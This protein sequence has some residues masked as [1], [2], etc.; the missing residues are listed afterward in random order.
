MTATAGN[1]QVELS[2][3]HPGPDIDGYHIYRSTEPF[4]TKGQSQR[5]T[6]S[7]PVT[8]TSYTDTEVANETTYYYRMASLRAPNIGGL[9][10]QVSAMPTASSLIF[11]EDFSDGLDGKWVPFGS[12]QGR[13]VS[14]V[15]N[16]AP[17]FDNNGDANWDSGAYTSQTFDYSNGLEIAAD[18]YVPS[19]P[20]GCWVSGSFGVAQQSSVTGQSYDLAVEFRYNYNGSLCN[21]NTDATLW[22][23][24]RTADGDVESIRDDFLSDYLDAWHRYRIVIRPDQRV[25]FYVDDSLIYRTERQIDPAYTNR[26]LVLGRRS[27]SYGKVYHDN[28]VVRQSG[29]SDLTPP[30]GLVAS[31][32]DGQVELSWEHP[33][34]DIDGYHIYRSTE[35]FETKGQSQRITG[36]DPVTETSYTDTEVAN[37]TTYYYRMA[38]LRAPNIG[39]L[40][41]QVNA[42]PGSADLND[43]LVAYYPFDGNA[44]DASGNGNDGTVSGARLTSDRNG[45]SESAYEFDGSNF[46]ELPAWESGRY[47][48]RS[49]VGWI[50]AKDGG[51]H[52][53]RSNYDASRGGEWQLLWNDSTDKIRARTVIQPGNHEPVLY[54]SR[55]YE[56]DRWHF[57]AAVWDLES[58]QVKLFINGAPDGT[59]DV[60]DGYIGLG[61][62]GLSTDWKIGGTWNGGSFNGKIDDVRIYNRALSESEI[63]Q[64]HGNE[65]AP[66]PPI[67]GFTGIGTLG[68][69]NYYFSDNNE[70]TWNEASTAAREVGGH[71]AVITSQGEGDLISS[72][73]GGGI[74]TAWIGLTDQEKEGEFRWVTG[75]EVTYSNWGF[76]QPDDDKD[77]EDGVAI[78]AGNIPSR[79]PGSWND[80]DI[81][82]NDQRRFAFVLEISSRGISAPSNL[83]ASPG[84]GQVELSWEHPG[85]DIDGY[86]IYRSTEPFETKGQSQRIT[87]SDP[88]TE[89]SYTDTEVANET[90]YY[91]RMASLRAP[92]I[93]GLS[94]QVSATPGSADLNDGLVAYY[95]FDG[96]AND[97]SGNGNDGAVVGAVLGQDRFGSADS[98]YKLDGDGDYIQI[99]QFNFESEGL[100]IATWIFPEDLANGGT[101]FSNGEGS[102]SCDNGIRRFAVTGSGFPRVH[103]E[104][105]LDEQGGVQVKEQEWHFLSLT[106][107]HKKGEGKIYLDGGVHSTF[108]SSSIAKNINT[109]ATHALGGFLAGDTFRKRDWFDG[110]MDDVRIYN[111]A[112]SESEITSLY[113]SDPEEGI[114]PPSGLTASAGDSQVELSWELEGIVEVAH[115]AENAEDPIEVALDGKGGSEDPPT[116][117]VTELIVGGLTITAPEIVP[118][119]GDE[120]EISGTAIVNELLQFDG[121]LTVDTE[122]LT[123]EGEGLIYME[124]MG[125]FDEIGL[126]DGSFYF[127]RG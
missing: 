16:P 115:N 7:D 28:I 111:R 109:N 59:A 63:K 118:V 27:S 51:G 82:G 119:S 56:K 50:L 19:A 54:T 47:S 72:F 35:P 17:A 107:N 37:E 121:T 22:A 52:F 57:V 60:P 80:F 113:N 10:E 67:E 124:D 126:Y 43:G 55:S 32:G 2:W 11:S 9:S 83:V 103:I 114:L 112:L 94:E 95:P 105:L 101:I 106:L 30:T 122:A 36:S 97:A 70:L 102:R 34:P 127:F 14:G 81:E 41:E 75:E 6:G 77:G 53:Q 71:L 88:V 12:P 79:V 46:I 85:P 76:G 90:T 8:E 73:V 44:D 74:E 86:H 61:N 110:S 91:Y 123:L 13:V 24:V 5:I 23:I 89:T 18:M 29:E 15:G 4:E 49:W 84:D 26:P 33:G 87:G 92:N 68:E 125:P 104:C 45:N 98:A 96:N 120:Y 108:D 116:E 42:T 93:G 38:S 62:G 39:G 20:N 48:S 66:P 64:L 3:E 69:S 1:A 117:P 100:T 58:D 40:S 99:P 25:E 31:A 65:V 21:S 78:W